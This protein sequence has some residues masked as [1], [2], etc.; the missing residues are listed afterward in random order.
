VN[1]IYEGVPN[2][3]L[4]LNYEPFKGYLKVHRKVEIVVF[5]LV[6][7]VDHVQQ[8]LLLELVRDIPD[9]DGCPLL[10]I[11]EDLK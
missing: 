3:A 10:L 6:V 7:L 5:P 2:I 4:S 11:I 9:H 8:G 1:E